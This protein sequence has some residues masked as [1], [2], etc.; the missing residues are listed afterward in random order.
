MATD[1]RG[2]SRPSNPSTTAGASSADGGDA[3]ADIL[4]AVEADL[5]RTQELMATSA[6]SAQST[7]SLDSTSGV[8]AQE[9]LPAL[10]RQHSEASWATLPAVDDMPPVPPELGER[11]HDLRAQIVALQAE[12]KAEMT[13]WRVECA[14]RR[15]PSTGTAPPE[16]H[17][18][19]RLA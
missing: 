15:A 17:Y 8:P 12:I 16:P 9:M 5:A 18:V 14:T 10:F 7:P 6:R 11:I 19:D 3:W 13:Q 1:E 4:A 2:A